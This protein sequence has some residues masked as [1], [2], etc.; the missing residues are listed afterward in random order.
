MTRQPLG[1]ERAWARSVVVGV[2]MR[3]RV[4]VCVCVSVGVCVYVRCVTLRAGG[5]VSPSESTQSDPSSARWTRESSS[6]P[7]ESR[8]RLA[9]IGSSLAQSGT[10][11]SL[12]VR[13]HHKHGA[14]TRGAAPAGRECPFSVSYS[15]DRPPLHE[16]SQEIDR[17][18]VQ[19]TCPTRPVDGWKERKTQPPSYDLDYIYTFDFLC[20]VTTTVLMVALPPR[21]H[22]LVTGHVGKIT[23][24]ES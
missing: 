2:S 6:Q 7:R 4:S 17:S 11:S 9:K 5:R 15:I 21:P 13:S 10:S 14:P 1:P 24:L 16:A 8:A 20:P 23:T 3:V 12:G 19:S 22:H 18:A